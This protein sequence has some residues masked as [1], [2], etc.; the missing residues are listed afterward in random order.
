MKKITR[1]DKRK[2][3][4]EINFF[5]EFVKLQKHFFKDIN[6]RLAAVKDP[7]HKSYIDYGTEV[8]LLSVLMKNACGIVRM[9]NMTEQFNKDECI[10]NI[11]RV[12][13]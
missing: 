7:R 12:L 10:E 2:K 11:S 3:E 1:E 13:G 8:M 5:E 4:R 6:K 9:T